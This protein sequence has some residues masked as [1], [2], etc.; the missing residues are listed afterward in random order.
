MDAT[1]WPYKLWKTSVLQCA[2]VADGKGSMS[3]SLTEAAVK[4]RALLNWLDQV[5][6]KIL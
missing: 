6:G 2:R 3:I 4:S 1:E 5:N